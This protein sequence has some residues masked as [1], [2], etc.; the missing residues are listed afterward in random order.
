MDL[1]KIEGDELVI[2]LPMEVLI[3]ATT[4][5]DDLAT[6]DEEKGDYRKV[7]VT[8]PQAW[9]KAVVTE[10]NSESEDGTTPVH[11][12]FDKAF[13]EA[14]EQGAEGLRIEGIDD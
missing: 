14:A 3:T 8:D 6:Y 12:M 11:I 13:S 7:E 2:R 1:A 5:C 10:L 4:H 9:M